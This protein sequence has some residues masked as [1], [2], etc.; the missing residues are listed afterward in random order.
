MRPGTR[1]FLQSLSRG[2]RSLPFLPSAPGSQDTGVAR[3]WRRWINRGCWRFGATLGRRRWVE[4]CGV[5]TV[6]LGDRR[7]VV[8]GGGGVRWSWEPVPGGAWGKMIPSKSFSPAAATAAAAA[9]A[10]A[11]AAG[12]WKYKKNAS[13]KC[14]IRV[15][16][17]PAG[18]PAWAGPP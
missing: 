15:S 16:G 5:G 17:P 13:E 11:G 8:P 3:A 10:A 1:P 14:H 18:P 2:T 9:A 4:G 6:F 7:G 12:A